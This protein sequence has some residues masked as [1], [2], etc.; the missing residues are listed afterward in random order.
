MVRHLQTHLLPLAV[1]DLQ[2]TTVTPSAFFAA[3]SAQ[4]P[5]AIGAVPVQQGSVNGTV[6]AFDSLEA[7]TRACSIGIKVDSFTIIG[8]P[9]LDANSTVYRLSLDKL[10]LLRPTELTPLL[11]SE[12]GRYGKVLHVGLLLDPST[13]LFFGKG[14]ALIDTAEDN[15]VK[16]QPL[17]HEIALSNHRIVFASWRG[18]EQHCFYCHKAGHTK[19]LCPQLQRQRNKTCYTCGSPDHLFRDCPKRATD[20]VGDKRQRTDHLSPTVQTRSQSKRNTIT[21]GDFVTSDQPKTASSSQ[22]T[23]VLAQTEPAPEAP[24][25]SPSSAATAPTKKKKSKTAKDSVNESTAR[26]TI[27]STQFND[28]DD[29]SDDSFVPDESEDSGHDSDEES[30]DQAEDMVV[31]NEEVNQLRTEAAENASL[32]CRGFKKIVSLSGRSFSRNLR[33]LPYD[34][35]AVQESHA[36]SPLLQDRFDQILQVSSSTWTSHCGLLSFNSML[37]ITPIWSSTDGRVLAAR[38]DHSSGIYEPFTV[39]V[40]Y[41]PSTRRDRELFLASLDSTLHLHQPPTSRCVLLGDFNH[42]VHRP[43]SNPLLQLW[44]NWISTF[45]HD[46]LHEDPDYHDLPTFRDIST[47]DFILVTGDFA[48][49]VCKPNVTYVARCDHAAVSVSLSLGQPRVGPGLWRGNPFLAQDAKFRE[50]LDSFCSGAASHFPAGE[51]HEQWDLFKSL[52]KSFIQVYCNKVSSQRNRKQASLQRQRRRLLRQPLD[53]NTDNPLADVEAQL[54]AEY[55]QSASILALRSGL[56][57][58]E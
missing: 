19:V 34:L 50:E 21:L 8:T 9:T 38:V 52:L 6:I 36:G 10:P 27:V 13:N 3:L 41:A 4:Y 55:E 18:M 35:L 2:S 54:D 24:S 7:R 57:W 1:F 49:S 31:D 39:Y 5:D 56:Q 12:L 37:R 14:Y 16:L 47:I 17:S 23:S 48:N 28:D 29:L 32:N 46:P 43:T 25:D 42:H 11:T 44:Y 30:Q 58:R 20:T 33:S 45:W 53:S 40:I 26:G 22:T 15:G 51:P